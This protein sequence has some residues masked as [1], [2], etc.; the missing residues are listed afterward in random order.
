VSDGVRS[1]TYAELNE[2][3]SRIANALRERGIGSGDR[4]ALLSRNSLESVQIIF[5]VARTGAMLVPLNFMLGGAEIGYVLGHSGSVALLVQDALAATAEQAI[6]EAGST[7]W[8]RARVV[9]GGD[10]EGWEPFAV[11]LEHDDSSEPT[12]MIRPDDPAQVLY[13]VGY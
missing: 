11:L 6:I 13:N 4:I 9:L 10:R 5:G 2:D 8:L 3:A 7:G 12:A 1:R